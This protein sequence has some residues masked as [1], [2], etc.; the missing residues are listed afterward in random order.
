MGA[1]LNAML[2]MAERRMAEAS[3][4]RRDSFIDG[5]LPEY[6]KDRRRWQ[7]IL[8]DGRIGTKFF[9]A[10]PKASTPTGVMV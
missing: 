7:E 8:S 5:W 6:M 3:D 9:D 2:E 1:D 4:K 10:K